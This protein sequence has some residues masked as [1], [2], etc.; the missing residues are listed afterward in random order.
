M[1]ESKSNSN[2]R[3]G[4]VFVLLLLISIIAHGVL[5]SARSV[6]SS[7]GNSS[8]N[9]WDT[10]AKV[11]SN[12]DGNGDV[13]DEEYQPQ[14]RQRAD[15]TEEE[16]PAEEQLPHWRLATDCSSY[17]LDCF[18]QAQREHKYLPYPFSPSLRKDIE[19]RS[20]NNNTVAFQQQMEWSVETFDHISEKWIARKQPCPSR[21]TKLHISNEGSTR[22]N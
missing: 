18:A 4:N 3:R 5:F 16:A 11:P 17:S 8:T 12:V 20:P 6:Q 10:E 15:Q 1:T 2:S 7:V 19:V 13:G 9:R 22:P 14:L 21:R